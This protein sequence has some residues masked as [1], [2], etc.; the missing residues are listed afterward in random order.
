MSLPTMDKLV[1]QLLHDLAVAE[2][3]WDAIMTKRYERA[4]ERIEEFSLLLFPPWSR[5]RTKM[6][7]DQQATIE[8]ALLELAR[9]AHAWHE[10]A[11]LKDG[12][13]AHKKPEWRRFAAARDA[14]VRLACRQLGRDQM[15]AE[16]RA[17][18]RA[19]TRAAKRA[20]G[21]S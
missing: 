17:A 1:S 11:V 21:R 15:A 6:L 7:P 9:S 2:M 18:K 20:G 12:T 5:T 16:L 4:Y 13:P 8:E 3:H 14:L 10:S 19:E